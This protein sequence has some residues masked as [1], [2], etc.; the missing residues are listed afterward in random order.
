MFIVGGSLLGVLFPGE[1]LI[2]FAMGWKWKKSN[3]DAEPDASISQR[4][5]FRAWTAAGG[6][7][8]KVFDFV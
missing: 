6:A 3:D 8:I 2:A 5:G 7:R 1:P 4:F